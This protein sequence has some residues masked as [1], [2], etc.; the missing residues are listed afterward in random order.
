MAKRSLRPDRERKK[1]AF[2]TTIWQL[3]GNHQTTS[4]QPHDNHPATVW[5]PAFEGLFW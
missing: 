4:P 5:Q 3:F 1:R 2:L